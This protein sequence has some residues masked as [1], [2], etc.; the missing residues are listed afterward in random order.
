MSAPPLTPTLGCQIAPHYEHDYDSADSSDS[1]SEDQEEQQDG[2]VPARVASEVSFAPVVEY[3]RPLPYSDSRGDRETADLEKVETAQETAQDVAA[4]RTPIRPI[5]R[6]RTK[7]N[8]SRQPEPPVGFFHWKMAGVRLH[9]LKLWLRTNLILAIAIFA[10]LSLFWGALFHQDKRVGI[11]KVLVVNF[12]TQQPESFQPF[13]GKYIEKMSLDPPL[14]DTRRLGWTAARPE[15]F[16]NDPI[17]VREAV[18]DFHAWAAVIINANATVDLEAAFLNSSRLQSEVYEPS[19]ACQIIVNSAR[20]PTTTSTYVL[21]ALID[22]RHNIMRYFGQEWI[23]RMAAVSP[24]RNLDDILPMVI[25]P[26]IDC[27]MIDL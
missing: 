13:V 12:D 3:V 15:E 26:G 4:V 24:P 11:L 1:S 25:S 14:P 10:L 17:K 23:P 9:V 19:A 18:Y 20:D 21:P 7:S 22:L 2:G 6:S 8:R 5:L 27:T 16:G